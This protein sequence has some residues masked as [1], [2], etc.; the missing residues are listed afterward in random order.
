MSPVGGFGGFGGGGDGRRIPVDPRF[1]DA[2]GDGGT[3]P[4][5]PGGEV[6]DPRMPGPRSPADGLEV[7]GPRFPGDPR[8]TGYGGGGGPAREAPR[9]EPYSGRGTGG[10]SIEMPRRQ[11]L[12][13]WMTGAPKGSPGQ[14]PRG[15]PI[16]APP[17]GRG[18]K[19]PQPAPRK[20]LPPWSPTPETPRRR[21]Y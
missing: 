12:P 8:M 6:E 17:T 18:S 19:Q 13:P 3:G 2:P 15:L 7:T 5:F 4:R 1:P 21:G 10:G 14:P 16:G 20:I 9:Y 11:L